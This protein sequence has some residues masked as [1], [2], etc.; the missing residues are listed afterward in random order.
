MGAAKL[1]QTSSQ[2][3]LCFSSGQFTASGGLAALSLS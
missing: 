1:L 2:L 3:F